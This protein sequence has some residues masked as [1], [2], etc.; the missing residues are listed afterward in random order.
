M[1]IYLQM[2]ETEEDKSK[3]E[4]LYLEYRSLLMRLACR[5]LGNAPDA[6]DAVHK[7]YVRLAEKIRIIEPVGP[8]TKKLLV[9][10]LENTVTDM[11][12]ERSRHPAFGLDEEA[13]EWRADAASPGE[14]LLEACILRLPEKQRAVIWLKYVFGYSLREIASL[15]GMSL[16]A[17]QKTDQR[18]K[19]KLEELYLEGGG[20]L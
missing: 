18:A 14:N 4:Q 11:L 13:E 5:R 8:K 7:V 19:Q 17:A 16:A 10:M 12:R 2:I 1:L 3:F 6:E 15:L 20:D 9:V